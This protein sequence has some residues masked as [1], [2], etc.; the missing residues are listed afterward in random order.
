M[1]I[2]NVPDLSIKSPKHAT[3]QIPKS[4][5][6][7]ICVY[8]CVCDLFHSLNSCWPSVVHAIAGAAPEQAV[9]QRLLVFLRHLHGSQHPGEHSGQHGS[10][11]A[12]TPFAGLSLTQQDLSF[13]WEGACGTLFVLWVGVLFADPL[14]PPSFQ[15][16]LHQLFKKSGR[17]ERKGKI[18]RLLKLLQ[19][20]S[21]KA[22]C[23]FPPLV[24]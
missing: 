17:K 24:S 6:A 21:M 7:C 8:V 16:C 1:T 14:C 20:P 12:A 10:L 2:S 5:C 3:T 11:L 4:V 15:S 22:S 13:G 19:F 23:L 18:K 9:G